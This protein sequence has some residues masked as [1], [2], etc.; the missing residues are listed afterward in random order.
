MADI[1]SGDF[2]LPVLRGLGFRTSI[3]I[4]DE[5]HALKALRGDYANVDAGVGALRA[6]QA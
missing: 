6:A 1:P 3:E 5:R 4:E 2:R